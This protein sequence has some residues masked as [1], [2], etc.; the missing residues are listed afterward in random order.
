MVLLG[1]VM[2]LCMAVVGSL[3]ALRL[4]RARQSRACVQIQGPVTETLTAR[5]RVGRYRSLVT[6]YRIGGVTWSPETGTTPALG[7]RH[8][9]HAL[10]PTGAGPGY[11]VILS[12]PAEPP[13][14]PTTDEPTTDEPTTHEAA[15][16]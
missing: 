8:I 5:V 13:H 15:G 10:A 6:W 12:E 7:Q 2:L 3:S 14:E 9:L 16:A 11:D 4:C 1:I